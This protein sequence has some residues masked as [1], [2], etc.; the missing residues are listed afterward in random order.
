MYRFKTNKRIVA[1][2]EYVTNTS[3]KSWI[4]HTASRKFHLPVINTAEAKGIS[5][6]AH[7]RSL[8]AKTMMYR[9]VG[10]RSWEFLYTSKQT[11]TFPTILMTFIARQILGSMTTSAK[12]R[13]CSSREDISASTW[14]KIKVYWFAGF[15]NVCTLVP[16]VFLRPTKTEF[17]LPFSFSVFPIPRKMEL[18][19][20]F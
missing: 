4:W 15:C 5:T 7:N 13:F 11:R 16:S 19:L 12:L 18:E 3:R 17:K 10:D 1:G 2:V 8:A 6:V 20:P 9:L 14:Y